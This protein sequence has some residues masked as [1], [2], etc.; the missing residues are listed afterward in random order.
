MAPIVDDSSY[1][2]NDSDQRSDGVVAHEKPKPTPKQKGYGSLV[3]SSGRSQRQRRQVS[4]N[5]D[6]PGRDVEGDLTGIS[7][8][9]VRKSG[10]TKTRRT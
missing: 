2:G 6:E 3:P 5:Y 4:Y 7:N 1:D 8:L 9:F 10:K